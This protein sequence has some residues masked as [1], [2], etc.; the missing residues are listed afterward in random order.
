MATRPP[1]A[2]LALEKARAE[3]A[4]KEQ[5]QNLEK[6]VEA[7]RLRPLRSAP[8]RI[9]HARVSGIAPRR[10]VVPAARG[11]RRTTAP[12]LFGG[13]LT[14]RRESLGVE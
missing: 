3:R 7:R 1:Q 14:S 5:E 12:Q 4:E 9:A 2:A 8:P 11:A 6:E 10:W 13:Q